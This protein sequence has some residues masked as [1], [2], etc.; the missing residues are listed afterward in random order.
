MNTL[1]F[2]LLE[3]TLTLYAQRADGSLGGVIWS[4][5]A[6]ENFHH[7]EK[8]LTV[9]TRPSGR[10]YPA[11][12][13]LVAQH[14]LSIERVWALPFAQLGGFVATEQTYVLAV[15]WLDEDELRWHRRIYYG[16][17]ISERSLQSRDIESGHVDNQEF[18]AEYFVV[19]S[20]VAGTLPP[21]V[22]A[23]PSYVVYRGTDGLATQLYTYTAGVYTNLGD[24]SL[25]TI[26]ADG[27]AI[28]FGVDAPVL[29]TAADGLQVPSLHDGFPDATP[30]LEFY[31]GPTLLAALTAD[32]L[33]SPEY[34]DDYA[35]GNGRF[36]F[37]YAGNPVAILLPGLALATAFNTTS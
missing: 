36:N 23:V 30:R 29:T 20:G 37:A 13:P 2:T 15:V 6:I 8:W 1:A 9:E 7:A 18:T 17:S 11:Q 34:A 4:G 31:Y 28:A 3:A 33:W 14:Q 5:A 24:G 12:H 10:R 25:A 27:S 35:G 16:A 26:A 22:L 21:P 32:G 19:D